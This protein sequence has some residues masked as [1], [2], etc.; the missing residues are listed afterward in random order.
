[1]CGFKDTNSFRL[2]DANDKTE[3]W[4]YLFSG[5]EDGT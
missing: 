4:R 1:V 5:G 3:Y 2:L